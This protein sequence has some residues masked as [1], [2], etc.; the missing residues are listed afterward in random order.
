[1]PD[2]CTASQLNAQG[3]IECLSCDSSTSYLNT[4]TKLCEEGGIANCK[5]FDSFSAQCKECSNGYY[6][7]ASNNQCNQ[8]DMI[9]QCST[10]DLTASNTCTKCDKETILYENMNRCAQANPE[11]TNCLIY[12]DTE[13]CSKCKPSYYLTNLGTRCLPIITEYHCEEYVPIDIMGNGIWDVYQAKRDGN[14]TTFAYTC[15]KC[16]SGYLR[17]KKVYTFTT[18]EQV[19]IDKNNTGLGKQDHPKNNQTY[20]QYTCIKIAD[21]FIVGE[22]GGQAYCQENNISG[23]YGFNLTNIDVTGVNQIKNDPALKILATDSKETQA[24]KLA[25]QQSQIDFLTLITPQCN[26]CHP[27]MYPWEIKGQEHICVDR[28]Y[29]KE[30]QGIALNSNCA[31]YIWKNIAAPGDPEQYKYVCQYCNFGYKMEVAVFPEKCIDKA[32]AAPA[33]DSYSYFNVIFSGAN[34]LDFVADKEQTAENF[35]HAHCKHVTSV[36]GATANACAECRDDYIHLVQDTMTYLNV[37][38]QLL[39]VE[40]PTQS[41]PSYTCAQIAGVTIKGF[42]QTLS[43]S[44]Y[45]NQ[46]NN[47]SFYGL[48]EGTTYGC[49]V[50]MPGYRGLIKKHTNGGDFFYIDDCVTFEACDMTSAKGKLMNSRKRGARGLYVEDATGKDNYRY[51]SCLHCSDNKIPTLFAKLATTQT[52]SALAQFKPD[53]DLATETGNINSYAATDGNYSVECIDLYKNHGDASFTGTASAITLSGYNFINDN[54]SSDYRDN[55]F[56]HCALAVVNTDTTMNIGH[57]KSDTA[58]V[59]N[60]GCAAC[61]PGYKPTMGTTNANKIVNCVAIENCE[62]DSGSSINTWFNACETCVHYI[63]QEDDG[64]DDYIIKNVQF[65]RCVDKTGR[66]LDNCFAAFDVGPCLVCKVGYFMKD[67]ECV[68]ISIQR[69]E[70]AN[71][72]DNFFPQGFLSN[73]GGAFSTQMK[74]MVVYYF[75]HE[76]IKGCSKCADNA[77][78]ALVRINDGI[79]NNQTRDRNLGYRLCTPLAQHTSPALQSNCAQY[80]MVGAEVKCKGCDA[81]Y[82]LTESY[83]CTPNTNLLHCVKANLDKGT[84]CV[85]CEPAYLNIGG[86]CKPRKD[87]AEDVEYIKDCQAYNEELSKE[88]AK[89][90]CESCKSGYHLGGPNSDQCL[91]NADP[92]CDVEVDG[93]CTKCMENS[94]WTK[95]RSN[96]ATDK[97]NY[98]C[99]P[100]NNSH[101]FF[102]KQFDA[103]G[104]CTECHQEG[105]LM[106]GDR[107]ARCLQPGQTTDVNCKTRAGDVCTECHYGYQLVT[108]TSSDQATSLVVCEPK[109]LDNLNQC[110][111]FDS[112]EFGKK[113]LVCTQCR[114]GYLLSEVKTATS[115]L[116]RPEVNS[117]CLKH[118]FPAAEVQY[119]DCASYDNRSIQ[120]TTSAT[121]FLGLSFR[122]L[123]CEQQEGSDPYVKHYYDKTKG[124]CIFRNAQKVANC[125]VH[126]PTQNECQ[127]C[128]DNY[129]LQLKEDFEEGQQKYECVSIKRK[130]DEVPWNKGYI[131]KCS[132]MEECEG[133][134]EQEG[135]P[136]AIST[137]L[138]CHQCKDAS[139]IPFL[140]V[141]VDTAERAFNIVSLQE[142]HF[143]DALSDGMFHTGK[144]GKAVECLQP[145]ASTFGLLTS[146]FAFP[147]NCGVGLILANQKNLSNHSTEPTLQVDS[148]DAGNDKFNVGVHCGS[149]LPGFRALKSSYRA[150]ENGEVREEFAFGHL[151]RGC[152]TISNCQNSNWFNYCSKCEAKYVYEYVEGEGVKYDQCIK[153]ADNKE[154]DFC[155]A[156]LKD[157]NGSAV[158]CRYCRKGTILNPDGICEEFNP[159]RCS[160][161]RFRYRTNYS[162]VDLATGLVLS[163]EGVGCYQCDNEFVG[164]YS[165]EDQ[166]VCTQSPYHTNLSVVEGSKYLENCVYYKVVDS[167]RRRC[168]QCAS[169]TVLTIEGDCVQDT[170]IKDC[171][172]AMN[173]K[174]CVQCAQGYVIILQQCQ[175][176]R[177][178]NCI[179]F[180]NDDQS[181]AEQCIKCGDGY[182]LE[183]NQCIAGKVRECKEYSGPNICELCQP[184]YAVVD[185]QD[186]SFCYPLP[187]DSRCSELDTNVLSYGQY[188]CKRC[189]LEELVLLTDQRQFVQS[190]CMPFIPTPNCKEYD[191]GVIIPFSS[192]KCIECLNTHFL[193][194]DVCVERAVLDNNCVSYSLDEDSCTACNDGYFLGDNGLSCLAYP[195]GIPNCL[196]YGIGMQCVSCELDYYLIDQTCQKLTDAQKIDN[197]DQHDEEVCLRCKEGFIRIDGS[198][199]QTYAKNCLTYESVN[200]CASCA[201]GNGFKLEGILLNCVAKNVPNCLDSD[202]YEPYTCYECSNGF[203]L[204]DGSC[205][206]VAN[207]IEGCEAYTSADKCSKCVTGS[208]LSQDNSLCLKTADVI[209]LLDPNC[210]A[211][212]LTGEPICNTCKDGFFFQHGYC[213]SCNENEYEE[214]CMNCD[215]QDNEICLVCRS[216]YY[217]AENQKCYRNGTVPE[218]V[219]VESSEEYVDSDEQK[220]EPVD[221][222][223][224]DKEE[225]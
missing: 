189:K 61:K 124:E 52:L 181:F 96:G 74:N 87:G 206:S 185:N 93:T 118:Y 222:T 180:G 57:F 184:G 82:V 29:L 224:K 20:D 197:C 117:R 14:S 37:R 40:D 144:G 140:S 114:Y 103:A 127:T 157:A 154:N 8:H 23:S 178:D 98:E 22:E 219:E 83:T 48:L 209:S 62:A 84:T 30:K 36:I 44:P 168:Q 215:P 58:G 89:A 112:A 2:N 153:F 201:A 159:P 220:P 32:I 26:T 147:S 208:A 80:G 179:L 1:M 106:A 31:R 221:P 207:K 49:L 143:A 85:E 142:Y 116:N 182:Y 99:F 160:F 217:M 156:A 202:N 183:N 162:S 92:N 107:I 111:A 196:E 216:G 34:V 139:K 50:C 4:A 120:P 119:E 79:T 123:S 100:V 136:L 13:T 73:S 164:I 192:F 54:S 28:A 190:I 198:C 6:Y 176:Q 200:A 113:N 148:V 195:T 69:C 137:L 128:D 64:S 88:S 166:Y 145:Q 167:E 169:G 10:Y 56:Q 55:V 51:F 174:H 81:D 38:D 193:D 63:E 18:T 94:V 15:N 35:G 191:K 11:L 125:K 43:T 131:Q 126:H 77:N 24:S 41:Y 72:G 138:S 122:C 187:E 175:V 97:E 213:M 27:G 212:K 76:K 19:Y 71:F 151:V 66:K 211:S 59:L 12:Q 7:T 194:G 9:H 47:C 95:L 78:H 146:E 158:E 60:V 16:V 223:D 188:S 33:T 3:V 152:E 186:G 70:N 149:C 210:S 150:L 170:E 67:D 177:I 46:I 199:I 104:Y 203:F 102:C 133:T 135:L 214:G 129:V 205:V 5:R 25:E 141:S 130:D 115:T 204:Q 165:P 17:Q 105:K 155:Y 110:T 91:R 173:P 39:E 108:K 45:V 86:V 225:N 42:I 134:T 161:G 101:D 132:Q 53:R 75:Q 218:V 172:L 65:D 171:V 121:Q 21:V 90:V 163:S 109:R 68:K